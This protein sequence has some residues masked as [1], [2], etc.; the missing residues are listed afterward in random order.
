MSER[1]TA[2]AHSSAFMAHLLSSAVVFIPETVSARPRSVPYVPHTGGLATGPLAGP[3][4]RTLDDKQRK[5][6][7]PAVWKTSGSRSHP[8][9][10][11]SIRKYVQ[12][13][14]CVRCTINESYGDY[15]YA[16]PTKEQHSFHSEP[17]SPCIRFA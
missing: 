9:K 8:R 3:G 6:A 17:P 13:Y 5:T 12:L 1:S 16:R 4:R 10:F 7:I 11:P 15:V 2:A 14:R